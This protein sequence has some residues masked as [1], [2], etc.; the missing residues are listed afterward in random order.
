MVRKY[1][2]SIEGRGVDEGTESKENENNE[3]DESFEGL[4]EDSPSF[5]DIYIYHVTPLYS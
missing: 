5:P 2:K 4:N 3:V 1:K